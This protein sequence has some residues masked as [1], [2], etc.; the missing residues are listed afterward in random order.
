MNIITALDEVF[1]FI[2]KTEL[3]KFKDQGLYQPILRGEAKDASQLYEYLNN[4]QC[5]WPRSDYRSLAQELKKQLLSGPTLQI[6]CGGGEMLLHLYHSGQKMLYGLDC[7]PAMLRLARQKLKGLNVKL[8]KERAE[9]IKQIS[10]LPLKNII[11][12]NFWGLL[13]KAASIKLLLDLKLKLLPGGQIIIGPNTPLTRPGR[14]QQA[15]KILSQE[16]DFH[17]NYPQFKNFS[18]LGYR[19]KMINA[20]GYEYYFL[21]RP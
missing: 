20:A 7:S 4:A 21:I 18:Q 1:S 15:E 13:P 9:N 14:K 6:G 3:R 16:L 11:I 8:I 12:H 2:P 19:V 10:L 5:S 17:F